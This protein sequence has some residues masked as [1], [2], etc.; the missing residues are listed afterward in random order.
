[1]LQ[2]TVEAET[3]LEDLAVVG[4]RQ[5][6]LVRRD[7]VEAVPHEVLHRLVRQQQRRRLLL[8]TPIAERGGGGALRGGSAREMGAEAG[9]ATPR[10]RHAGGA[11]PDTVPMTPICGPWPRRRARE[12]PGPAKTPNSADRRAMDRTRGQCRRAHRLQVRGARNARMERAQ[13]D[14]QRGE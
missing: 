5:T 11:L 14:A 13:N 6:D 8:P 7:R 9:E 2:R 4:G 12:G 10:R 1:M 3:G